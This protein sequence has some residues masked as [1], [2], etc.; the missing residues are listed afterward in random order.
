MGLIETLDGI[1]YQALHDIPVGK[2]NNNRNAVT[3]PATVSVAKITIN[4][5]VLLREYYDINDNEIYRDLHR[6]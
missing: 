4:I 6:S 1:L 5:M 3:R 2:Y